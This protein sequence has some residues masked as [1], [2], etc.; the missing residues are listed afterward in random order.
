MVCNLLQM[1]FK[2]VK[3]KIFIDDDPFKNFWMTFVVSKTSESSSVSC[4]LFWGRISSLLD[5]D[6]IMMS[7]RWI[8]YGRVGLWL[9]YTALT[10]SR[11]VLYLSSKAS[12]SLFMAWS[13]SLTLRLEMRL[14]RSVSSC[15]M[16]RHENCLWIFVAISHI[17]TTVVMDVLTAN[18]KSVL[19]K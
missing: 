6:L 14:C 8:I 13:A 19:T 3:R 12:L 7:F 1:Y 18:E 16:M 11:S 17:E 4:L 9:A 5:M 2:F 10:S 15:N